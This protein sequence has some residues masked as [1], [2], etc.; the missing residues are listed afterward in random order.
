VTAT[1]N[2][3]ILIGD[4]SA[5][6]IR[7][8]EGT[9][10][11]L[12][13]SGGDD[14]IIGAINGV[15]PGS[16]LEGGAGD[17]SLFSDGIGDI[18]LG[19]AG[20][21]TLVNESG[22]AS[23]IGGA[24]DDIF[25]PTDEQTT[26]YGGAGDD[27]VAFRD[28]ANLA[29]GEDGDD[30]IIGGRGNDIF[31]G[32]AGD[33]YIKAFQTS[34]DANILFG[35]DGDDILVL[36]D[37]AADSGYGGMGDDSV[38]AGSGASAADQFLSGDKGNDTITYLGSGENVILD[39]D[40]SASGEPT[41]GTDAGN[42]VFSVTAAKGM[43][44]L[45]GGGNDSLTGTLGAESEVYMGKGDD[46]FNVKSSGSSLFSGDLGN[47]SGTIVLAGD[48]TVWADGD[49]VFA[50]TDA[51][52]GN[53][54]LV[55]TGGVGGNVIY[56]DIP[57]DTVGGNDTLDVTAAG[58]GNLVAGGG[59]NDL[60]KSG[61]GNT[62]IGGA[63]NDIYEL[64]AGDVIPFDSLGV[65]TYVAGSGASVSDVVTV[66]PGDSFTGGATFLVTGEAELIKTISNGGIIA[67]D[68]KDL[69]TI[70]TADQLT[71]LKAGDDTLQGVNLT[72]SGSVFGGAGNDNITFSGTDVA[73][74][75]DG[76]AGNDSISFTDKTATVT[77]TVVGGAGVDT[78][79][80]AGI[81]AGSASS[82]DVFQVGTLA[83]GASLG[84]GDT[85]VELI[86]PGVGSGAAGEEATV[87]G[88]A[89]ADTIGV[90]TSSSAGPVI[91]FGNAGDDILRVGSGGN[92]TLDGG[93]G[94]DTLISSPGQGYAG[95]AGTTAVQQGDS[96]FGGAG[97]DFFGFAGTNKLGF[98]GGSTSVGTGVA[99]PTD[100]LLIGNG[101]DFGGTGYLNNVN[102]DTISGF[103]FAQG[104]RLYFS[105]D[106]FG[107]LAGGTYFTTFGEGSNGFGN[108][109]AFSFAG[110]GLEGAAAPSVV[111][112]FGSGV[113]ISGPFGSTV[114]TGIM[115][116]TGV[117]TNA[118]VFLYEQDAGALYYTVGSSAAHLV[119]IFDNK[120]TLTQEAFVF[121]NFSVGGG[122]T[123]I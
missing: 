117:G 61:G 5:E 92:A 36:S 55:L 97:A 119:A 65:N 60:L 14:T 83:A 28:E 58:S 63:G 46:F 49:G 96:L 87:S 110:S 10:S 15:A 121:G 31:A 101:T 26:V 34:T 59:G 37:T 62:L 53:D 94:N 120:P 78:L 90:G 23:L 12:S 108:D 64:S 7:G 57:T 2:T 35:N 100:G 103:D 1:A 19:G 85:G 38:Y 80:V 39:G 79:A 40:R 21:D 43:F 73:G 29:Y 44:V 70:G 41:L 95:T 24:G 4:D 113:S 30:T 27:S 116:A 50:G 123:L 32:G 45:G 20:D 13:G 69:I 47:D 89:G 54:N 66:Q 17:D 51:V 68:S 93:A 102:V 109:D 76:G 67:S 25:L 86:I 111:G 16:T 52:S 91:L 9:V 33:D 6:L 115:A 107:T 122:T 81:F 105:E 112:A 42:D 72:D 18:V 3:N 82:I 104:D 22:Q 88:G 77:A 98:I 99:F 106:A 74:L 84:A 8:A 71:D 118:G 11:Y 114:G 56:G 75:V 48:D